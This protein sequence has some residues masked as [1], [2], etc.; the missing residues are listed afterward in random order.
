MDPLDRIRVFLRVAELASFTQAA[1]A[2]GL[3]KGSVSTAVSQLEAELG[4]RLLHRTT[5]RV[6][7]TQDGHVFSERARDL[8]SD[9]E[10]LTSHFRTGASDLRGRIR[11]DMSTNFAQNVILP[12]LPDFLA[13]HPGID[14]ELSSTER[15]VDL[16]Q[17]GFDFT[18]RTSGK[19]DPNLIAR[20][21]GA[22]RVMSVVSRSYAAK[23][24]VP[25]TLEDLEHHRIVHYATVFGTPPDGFE[26]VDEESGETR[27]V[28]MR[29]AVTVS[30]AGAYV[31][32]AR[33]GLGLV[34]VPEVGVRESVLSG[35]LLEVLAAYPCPS[36]PVY[37]VYLNRRHQ[38]RRVRVFMDW[39]GALVSAHLT[40]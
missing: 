2:L 17:E 37:L 9:L 38:P 19:I 4:A 1:H 32:A 21:L 15:M 5:R 6:Q 40:S 12:R 14:V 36:L 3:P 33:A 16:A 22:F 8:V 29:G 18:V 31:A 7:L 30:S 24:G 25:Q 26:Y 34:Q 27:T 13:E 20:P 10:E 11:V 35:E 39:I 28:P 23:F